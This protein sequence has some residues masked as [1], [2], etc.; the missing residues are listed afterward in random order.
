MSVVKVFKRM[1]PALLITVPVFLT[2]CSSQEDNLKRYIDEVKARPATPIP[3]IPAEAPP[4]L[5][6]WIRL[7]SMSIVMTPTNRFM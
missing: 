3:P 1:W 5:N 7:Q 6:I 4:P 2:A